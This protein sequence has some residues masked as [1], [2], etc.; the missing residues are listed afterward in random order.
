MV[1]NHVMSTAKE[2]T[3]KSKIQISNLSKIDNGI[4]LKQMIYDPLFKS[5]D[6][7]KNSILGKGIKMETHS[8]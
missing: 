5:V 2:N 1:Q 6:H 8:T 7:F 4:G 3:K